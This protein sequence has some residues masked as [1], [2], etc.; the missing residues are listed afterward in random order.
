[1]APVLLTVAALAYVCLVV[2]WAAL[3]ARHLGQRARLAGAI[4]LLRRRPVRR[5]AV[6]L[7]RRR[8]G[9]RHPALAAG[10][11]LLRAVRAAS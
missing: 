3:T 11:A 4:R 8:L 1:V 9:R 5:I 7:A 2:G 6:R 10:L